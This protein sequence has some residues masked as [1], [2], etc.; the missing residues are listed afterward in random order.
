MASC[1]NIIINFYQKN[2]EKPE[3]DQSFQVSND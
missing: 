2:K 3:P 1:Q